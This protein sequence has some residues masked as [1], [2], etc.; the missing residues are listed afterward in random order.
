M[1]LISTYGIRLQLYSLRYIKFINREA[2]ILNC[3]SSTSNHSLPLVLSVKCISYKA[4]LKKDLKLI[5]LELYLFCLNFA[6]RTA[7]I[8][9]S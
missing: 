5:L 8:E 1:N 6:L 9:F 4:D 3:L 7:K 2:I